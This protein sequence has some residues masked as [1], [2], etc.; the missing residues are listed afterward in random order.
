MKVLEFP[1]PLLT[2]IPK[3]LRQ[4]ADDIER[5][6][7]GYSDVRRVVCCVDDND[8]IEIRVYLFGD[9]SA[10]DTIAVLD[11]GLDRMRDLFRGSGE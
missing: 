3:M 8:D 2:D 5:K 7:D 1:K 9:G 4:L 11:L 10:Y 6:A